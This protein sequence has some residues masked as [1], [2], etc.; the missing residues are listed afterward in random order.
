MKKLLKIFFVLLFLLII[1][2]GINKKDNT[3]FKILKNN[4]SF[5]LGVKGVSSSGLGN[6]KENGYTVDPIVYIYNTHENESYSNKSYENINVNP[7]V[8]DVS[9]LLASLLKER[10]IPTLVEENSFVEFQRLNNWDYSAL[11]KVSRIYLENTIKKYD[12]IKLYIDLHRDSIKKSDSTI[13]LDGKKYAKILFVVGIN[14]P[15]YLDNYK[16]SKEL[17]DK[18]CLTKNI[19]RG[20]LKKTSANANGIYNQD[21]D[22]KVV[23][24]EIGGYQNSIEE[25]T[26]TLELIANSLKDYFNV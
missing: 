14:N 21:L 5:D 6:I 11:Y 17:N 12:N 26:N 9:F 8:K 10:G 22:K 13:T 4:I 23:L 25:V 20:I 1:L 18:I 24:L 2:L 15:N 7:T 19:C 16:L 3:F